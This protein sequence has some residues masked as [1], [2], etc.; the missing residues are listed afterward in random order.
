[1]SGR[2]WAL[3]G[4]WMKTGRGQ[5]SILLVA[6]MLLSGLLIGTPLAR[7]PDTQPP[8]TLNAL[9]SP[10]I[11]F[12]GAPLAFSALI[13]DN[14][15]GNSYIIA[16]EYCVDAPCPYPMSGFPMDATDGMFGEVMEDVN[17]TVPANYPSGWHYVYIHGEDSANNWGNSSVSP[18][19]VIVNGTVDNQGPITS[20]VNAAPDPVTQGDPITFTADVDDSTT[21]GNLTAAAEF[22]IDSPCPPPYGGG[23]PMDAT[24]GAFDEM[25]EDVN[26]TVPATYALG[27]HTVCVRGQDSQGNVGSSTCHSFLVVGPPPDN[28]PGKPTLLTAVLSG[29][30]VLFVFL[31]STD[32][33]SGENDVIGYR[34]YRSNTFASGGAGYP[35]H[36]TLPAGSSSYTDVGAGIGDFTDH[37]YCLQSMDSAGQFSGCF[38]QAAKNVRLFTAGRH[39]VSIPTEQA[40]PAISTVLQTLDF[41]EARTYQNPAGY[42][43][44]WLVFHKNKPWTSD[45]SITNDIALWVLVKT[46]SSLVTAGVI[47]GVETVPLKTGWNFRAYPSFIP[48]TV[49]TAFA[50][51]SYQAIEGFDPSQKPYLL[52]KLTGG[53]MLYPFA[54][55]WIHVNYDQTWA[56]TN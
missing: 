29:G 25:A 24:D 6:G 55:L 30:N 43:K 51:I 20:N 39:L 7:A 4:K 13:S 41:Q 21:G 26:K 45:F 19:Y 16:A 54:G 36:S 27:N 52:R 17:K 48:R 46:D 32:D 37:F 14:G 8:V 23:T 1:M 38:D 33:G 40:D 35:L 11:V 3:L 22:C 10:E 2:M 31:P 5:G 53:D 47:R 34:V 56:L 9:A 28:P 42:G 12:Y 18:F 50:G 15:T 44:N 49:S